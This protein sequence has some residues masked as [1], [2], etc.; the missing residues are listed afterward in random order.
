LND[1]DWR[2]LERIT[3]EEKRK[4]LTIRTI[5]FETIQPPAEGI[6]ASIRQDGPL[7]NL[8]VAMS[9]GKSF[10]VVSGE[11]RYRALRRA[12]MARLR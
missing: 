4:T 1:R 8:V 7:L 3:L 9:R 12:P 10:R 2:G 11:R 6:A 5:P